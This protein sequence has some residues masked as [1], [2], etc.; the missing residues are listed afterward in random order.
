MIV[1]AYT[2]FYIGSTF[3]YEYL[4]GILLDT[5]KSISSSIGAARKKQGARPQ[6]S[7]T[8]N[9]TTLTNIIHKHSNVS[10]SNLARF[11]KRH[12]SVGGNALRAAVL[13][14]N[15]GLVSNFSLVMAIAGASGVGKKYYSL[16]SQVCWQGLCPWHSENGSP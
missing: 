10:A 4:L 5:E 1:M 13:G 16:E 8:A 6:I 15:D 2:P 9:V 12:R 7:D 3:G 11:D 14:G